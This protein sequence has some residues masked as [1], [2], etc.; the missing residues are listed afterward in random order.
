MEK[1]DLNR[2]IVRIS[3]MSSSEID[4][5]EINTLMNSHLENRDKCNLIGAV[6]NRKKVLDTYS[7]LIDLPDLRHGEL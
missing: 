1:E 7:A 2:W 6:I 5:F 4:D 3:K